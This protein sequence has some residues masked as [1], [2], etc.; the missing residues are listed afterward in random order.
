MNQTY[1]L[2]FCYP[3]IL[4]A[5]I[6]RLPADKFGFWGRNGG[7]QPKREAV[8]DGRYSRLQGDCSRLFGIPGLWLNT[9]S[10]DKRSGGFW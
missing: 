3:R 4:F 6:H 2:G 5:R 8:R 10:M 1:H 9:M 7:D